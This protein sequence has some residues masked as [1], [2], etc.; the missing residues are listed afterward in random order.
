MY[1]RCVRYG[2][3]GSLVLM[4]NSVID[5]MLIA[6][7]LGEQA[8]ASFGLV[9][10]A[11]SLINL[12]PILLRSSVQTKIGEYLGRG[13]T[14]AA[15][16]CLFILLIAGATAAAILFSMFAFG[17]AHCMSLL[18]AGASYSEKTISI[19]SGYMH[20]ISVSVFPIIICSVLHPVMHLDGDIKRSARA[21][22]LGTMVNISG[23]LIN[24]LLLNGGM[25]GMAIATDL[26]CFA[27]LAWL[28]LHYRKP[29]CIL[30]PV[31]SDTRIDYI[32]LFASG[33]PFMIRELT[34]FISGILLNRLV[35]NLS[36]AV[37]IS[38]LCIGNTIWLFMLPAAAA[39]SSAGNTLGS[40]SA[41]ESDRRGTCLVFRMGILY[42]LIPGVI[43]GATFFLLAAPFAAFC[44]SDNRENA[45]IAVVLLRF[46][47]L[48][49]P[50]TMICQAMESN[51]N[52]TGHRRCAIF[53][54]ILEGGMVLWVVSMILGSIYGV[55]GIWAARLVAAIIIA[56]IGFAVSKLSYK[57]YAD[58]NYIE[59]TVST[60]TEVTA[61]SEQVRTL[62]RRNNMNGRQSNLAALCVEELACNTLLWGY[63][64]GAG[65]GIDLRAAFDDGHVSIRIRDSGRQFDPVQYTRQFV[66]SG[67]DPLKNFGLR[68]VSGLAADMRYSCIADCNIVL[69]KI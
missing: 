52:V 64:K 4:I 59:E 3:I 66:P 15:G 54:S 14:K 27:E 53:L 68:I 33:L 20:L 47:A 2:Y 41:G 39:I 28:L 18:S 17:G 60:R 38:I 26:S 69:L 24:V 23:D 55:A 8:T 6:H 5:G 21:V 11:Y 40:V 25:A 56:I 49:L 57:E 22:Q 50:V 13:N 61:F 65:E 1:C 32:S 19:A 31:L 43:L 34:A 16:H 36:G 37:G 12:I 30:K 63:E 46:L 67:D 58:D 9:M 51:L 44:S 45:E 7:F 48:S 42:S 29:G 35:F 10:P 62:C